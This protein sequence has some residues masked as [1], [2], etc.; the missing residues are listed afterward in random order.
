MRPLVA[1]LHCFQQLEGSRV[2]VTHFGEQSSCC[3]GSRDWPGATAGHARNFPARGSN[4][5]SP[6]DSAI[7]AGWPP[8]R[9]GG[10]PVSGSTSDARNCGGHSNTLR[11]NAGTW[12]WSSRSSADSEQPAATAL[13]R[14][15][16]TKKT[17]PLHPGRRRRRRRR[18]KSF[19][20]SSRR[21]RHSNTMRFSN[22]P[23]HAL[24]KSP[25][26]A[27]HASKSKSTAPLPFF[28]DKILPASDSKQRR[29][30]RGS[31]MVAA[32]FK[33]LLGSS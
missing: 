1:Q 17:H 16:S 5:G 32:H 33:A 14:P 24:F 27:D 29:R 30:N 8:S 21:R 13:A 2:L 6:A 22:R 26:A 28:F 12:V 18:K 31:S 11:C 19:V 25:P 10:N 9:P 7:A 23:N 4:P 20:R 15:R 3:A